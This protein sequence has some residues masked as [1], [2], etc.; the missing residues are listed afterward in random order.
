MNA[1]FQVRGEGPE[2]THLFLCGRLL[3]ALAHEEGLLLAPDQGRETLL[4]HQ[5]RRSDVSEFIT[6]AFY[7]C[8]ESAAL[9]DEV[10]SDFGR[11]DLD[12][13]S[14]EPL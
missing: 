3:E 8:D 11:N 7:E 5:A 6:A 13:G 10:G 14:R 9:Q 4:G 1:C 2:F 12:S